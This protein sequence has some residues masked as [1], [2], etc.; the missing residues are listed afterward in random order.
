MSLA[1]SSVVYLQIDK[2]SAMMFRRINITGY[3]RHEND[4]TDHEILQYE[5]M[6][7]YAMNIE[8]DLKQNPE[9]SKR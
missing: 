6:E 3:H 5:S 1:Q 7:I 4:E 8:A 9:G 2:C